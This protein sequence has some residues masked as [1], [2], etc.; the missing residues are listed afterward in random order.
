MIYYKSR[1]IADALGIKLA[2][3]KRWARE[4]LPPDPLS[5]QQSGYARNFN[6]KDAFHVYLAGYLVGSMSFSIAQA[7]Q[8]LSDLGPSLKQ[9]G[10]HALHV[11]SLSNNYMLYW[12]L[13][14]PRP[15]G[16][17]GYVESPAT[18]PE[19]TMATTSQR[20]SEFLS[21]SGFMD[22]R[23][24]SISALYHHFLYRLAPSSRQRCFSRPEA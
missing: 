7:G 20:L 19:Q 5:G 17:F 6:I 8:I 9:R 18:K 23:I 1:Y 15:D 16:G 2:K 12:V 3:W 21:T 11:N 24:I 14:H 13:I 10:Y 4:F 22:A